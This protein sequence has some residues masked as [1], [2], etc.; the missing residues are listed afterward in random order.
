MQHR[1]TRSELAH[2]I[3]Q[4]R[5]DRHISIRSAAR[6]AGVPAATAQG[7]LAGRHFPT[8]ALRPKFLLLVEAL[9]LSDH[10]HPAL[11]LDDIP[12]PRISE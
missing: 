2:L 7:W 1:P 3:N 9:E 5:L 4:A 6:I 11:W 12:E 8:P 10:L